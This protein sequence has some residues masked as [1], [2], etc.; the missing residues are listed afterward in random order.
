MENA[1]HENM[2]ASLDFALGINII[3][4][5]FQMLPDHTVNSKPFFQKSV[6]CN[7]L[8]S[9]G[10]LYFSDLRD[11]FLKKKLFSIRIEINASDSVL[12]HFSGRI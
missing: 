5:A 3:L 11:T 2:I 1:D 4:W 7:F 6:Q 8:I 12:C 9:F 10:I